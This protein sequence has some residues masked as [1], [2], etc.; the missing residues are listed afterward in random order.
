MT[1]QC[2]RTDRPGLEEE[3]SSECLGLRGFM[4]TLSIQASTVRM[5][6]C[7]PHVTACRDVGIAEGHGCPAGLRAGPLGDAEFAVKAGPWWASDT[8]W[9]S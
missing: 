9:P 7:F 6:F 4:A 8:V 2:W 1:Q 5:S 3:A